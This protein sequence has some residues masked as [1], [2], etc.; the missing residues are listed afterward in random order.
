MPI[1]MSSGRVVNP[2]DLQPEDV[3]IEDI[4][5]AL[6]KMCRWGGKCKVFFSVAD[7]SVQVADLVTTPAMQMRALLHDAAEAYLWDA[8]LPMKEYIYFKNWDH[9]AS[10]PFA[11]MERRIL[12]V[13]SEAL[14]L[15]HVGP[16]YWVPEIEYADRVLL[17]TEAR[18]IMHGTG[19]WDPDFV[20]TLPPPDP[21]PLT[22]RTSDESYQA[23]MDMYRGLE[24]LRRR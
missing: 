1:T 6:S 7:H 4:A 17:V 5:A 23:F 22:I 2:L 19:A 24:S 8:P 20:A 13:I 15:L 9:S 14:G 21:D 10:M 18:D 3:C 12:D 11:V 16:L